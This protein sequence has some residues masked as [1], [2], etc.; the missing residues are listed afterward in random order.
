MRFKIDKTAPKNLNEEEHGQSENKKFEAL[1]RVT[2]LL[3]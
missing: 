3:L 2:L 1:E